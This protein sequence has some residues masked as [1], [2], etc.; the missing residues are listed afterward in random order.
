MPANTAPILDDE[1]VTLAPDA[2]RL[3][4]TFDRSPLGLRFRYFGDHGD[5][6]EASDYA[7][8]AM[9]ERRVSEDLLAELEAA[10]CTRL[11]H[12]PRPGR[13]WLQPDAGD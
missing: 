7:L 13:T 1:A 8:W 11:G 6:E 4:D 9:P 12:R 5:G 3:L 2:R 10:M